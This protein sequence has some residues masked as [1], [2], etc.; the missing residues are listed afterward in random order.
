MIKIYNGT[1]K[2]DEIEMRKVYSSKLLFKY[3]ITRVAYFFIA[4][5]PTKT[6]NTVF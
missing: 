5:L 1:P 6:N 3:A 2:K 4:I